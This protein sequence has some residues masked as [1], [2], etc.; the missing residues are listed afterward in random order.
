MSGK[1]FVRLVL[2][3]HT[4]TDHNLNR[5]YSGQMDI[6][7]NET[8]IEQAEL[9]GV[10]IAREFTVHRIVT[11]DLNRAYVT[12][13]KIA[14][15]NNMPPMCVEPRLREVDVG[16]MTGLAKTVVEVEFPDEKYRSSKDRY[17]YRDIGGECAE[18]VWLRCKAAIEQHA[19]D[20]Y[21]SNPEGIPTLVVVGHGTALR[22]MFVSRLRAFEKLH[23]QG[24]YQVYDWPIHLC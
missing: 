15:P 11:S 13:C 20:L 14:F 3:R 16:R 4:Q 10:K 24:D 7:L 21:E 23:E 2:C 12:A 19:L 1:P 8:G 9:L 6:S 5:V 18:D 22:T 17:D